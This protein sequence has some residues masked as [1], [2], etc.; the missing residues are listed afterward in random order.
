MQHLK[1]P[2]NAASRCSYQH[3]SCPQRLINCLS[4][5]HAVKKKILFKTCNSTEQKLEN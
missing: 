3:L 1:D 5:I 4:Y 2:C